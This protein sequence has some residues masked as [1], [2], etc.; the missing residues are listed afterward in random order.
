[1][2]KLA[3]FGCC[4][5]QVAAIIVALVELLLCVL[6]LY[7]LIRNFEMFGESYLPWLLIG[8]FSVVVLVLAI[9]LLLYAIHSRRALWVLPHFSAQLF[10]ILFL[11]ALAI[12]VSLLLIFGFYGGIRRLLGH[13]TYQMSDSSTQFIGITIV[14]LYLAVALLEVLF[15]LIVYRL[16]VYL[17]T[18]GRWMPPTSDETSFIGAGSDAEYNWQQGVVTSGYNRGSADAGDIYPYGSG[19]R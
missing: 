5:I 11:V 14:V 12:V 8:I 19:R 2:S 1:M 15:A 9:G 18:E 3:T 17:K 7:G 4:S 10:L 6:C 13:D 16:Y